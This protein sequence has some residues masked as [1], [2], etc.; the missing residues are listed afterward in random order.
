MKVGFIGLGKLG[1]PV[2][3]TIAYHGHNVMGYDIDSARMTKKTQPYKE[4]GLADGED[5]NK[6]YLAKSKIRFR[7]LQEVVDHSEILFVAVQTPHSMECE[8]ITPL[9]QLRTDF[10]YTYLRD[11]MKQITEACSKPTI[12]AVISTV[13]PGTMQRVIKPI[14]SKNPNIVLAYN[15]SFIAMGT[16]M[17][18]YVS[19]E[20]ILLGCENLE[21]RA[22]LTDFYRSMTD[23]P[24]KYMRIASAELTKVT[25][26]TFITLKIDYANTIM[27]ICDKLNGADCEEV[28]DALR[29]A[30]ARVISSAYLNPGMGD[31]GGC[32]PRD[33]IALSW[34][35]RQL[36]LSF[37]LFE[38]AIKCRE[39][40]ALWLARIVAN[41]AK[42]TGLP[43]VL[44]GKAFK[45]ETNLLDGS[46]AILT[47][48][49]VRAFGFSVSYVDDNIPTKRTEEEA[50]RNKAVFLISCRHARYS[51]W[52]FPD[53]SVVIDPHRYIQP[54]KNYTVLRLGEA[55]D[56]V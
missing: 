20:F 41:Q 19:P 3:V 45:A 24:M 56:N 40:Q 53:G 12:V 51:N 22:T 52:I 48:N 7:H 36:S 49:F 34:L 50:L 21:A 35:A 23:A 8:G 37:D 54:S 31:G 32:H 28:M 18:D 30:T 44:L 9:P 27:E 16:V 11:S 47:G 1:L 17:R 14:I 25:Y 13:L 10:N 29:C 55:K 39:H 38:A 15:P 2:A 46:P 42:K 33:N 4:A 43:I 5:F 6:D 26:N